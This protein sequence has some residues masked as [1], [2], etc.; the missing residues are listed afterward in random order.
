MA[1]KQERTQELARRKR[2]ECGADW[3][4]CENGACGPTFAYDDVEAGF[5]AIFVS[6]PGV[7]R[8]LL[9]RSSHAR[10]EENM[11]S[12]CQAALDLLAEC[13]AEA[14]AAPPPQ[15]PPPLLEVKEDRYGGVEV[16]VRAGAACEVSG[17][18]AE[19]HAALAAWRAAGKRGVWLRLPREAHAFVSAA[20]GAGFAYHH[21][22][23]AYLQ[24]TRWLP[25]KPSPLPRYAFTQVGV[26]GVV[27]NAVCRVGARSPD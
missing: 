10:R 18:V 13:V 9:V 25:P 20:V 26:G 11:W 12:F 2:I 3:C 5:T 23:P 17:F 21:A 19:L 7:E 14:A 1:S 4:I 22:T 8:G 27:V 15:P 16:G 24:L 6:G